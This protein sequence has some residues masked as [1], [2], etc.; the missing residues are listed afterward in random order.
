M[1][2]IT[3]RAQGCGLQNNQE[4]RGSQTMSLHTCIPAELLQ[5]VQAMAFGSNAKFFANTKS[6]HSSS[7]AKA[8]RLCI[9][10]R[11]VPSIADGKVDGCIGDACGLVVAQAALPQHGACA[12]VQ[13]HVARQRQVHLRTWQSSRSHCTACTSLR[14]MAAGRGLISCGELL[15]CAEFIHAGDE[16]AARS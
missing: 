8:C 4:C 13:V 9:L 1:E 12:R 3:H 14:C 16:N 5:I 11:D 7:N 10:M 15:A 6:Y 2:Q